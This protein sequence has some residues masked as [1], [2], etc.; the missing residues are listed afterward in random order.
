MVLLLSTMLQTRY[1]R[2]YILQNQIILSHNRQNR[3]LR[4][5]YYNS[6]CSNLNEVLHENVLVEMYTP[7]DLHTKSLILQVGFDFIW[8][9]C[10][11]F[12][13]QSTQRG[14]YVFHFTTADKFY[15]ARTMAGTAS[16]RWHCSSAKPPWVRQQGAVTVICGGRLSYGCIYRM[17]F[18][19]IMLVSISMCVFSMILKYRI[20]YSKSKMS[21]N[22]EK[23][24][25]E[26]VN[27]STILF[28]M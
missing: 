17:Q 9:L 8:Y 4:T 28:I 26:D 27:M 25:T 24:L 12:K 11:K 23:L 18:F 21:L 15:L 5:L 22:R 6:F 2:D 1:A 20:L 19:L 7:P 13:V 14:F 16:E 10:Q 3:L